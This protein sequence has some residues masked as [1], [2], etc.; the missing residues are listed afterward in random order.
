MKTF[1]IEE[2]MDKDRNPH[3]VT[4]ADIERTLYEL[5][6]GITDPSGAD[7]YYVLER[8][9]WQLEAR[10]HDTQTWPD[11]GFERDGEHQPCPFS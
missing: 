6:R 11:P 7:Y 5:Y 10:G 1:A 9:R 4:P 2:T 3:R 8:A